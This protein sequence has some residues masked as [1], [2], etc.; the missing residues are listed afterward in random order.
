MKQNLIVQFIK[1]LFSKTPKRLA[2]ARNILLILSIAASAVFTLNGNA[3]NAPDWLL[4]ICSPT[5]IIAMLSGA[6][7]L[8]AAKKEAIADTEIE[9]PQVTYEQRMA[10]NTAA[11]GVGYTVHQIDAQVGYWRINTSLTWDYLGTRPPHR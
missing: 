4:D 9:Y 6:F 2:I 1:G 11:F 5:G 7:G 8:Q 3:F 10:I